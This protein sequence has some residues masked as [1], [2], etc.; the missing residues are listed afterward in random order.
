MNKLSSPLVKTYRTSDLLP[1][2]IWNIRLHQ[3]LPFFHEKTAKNG[4]F[5]VKN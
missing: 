3:N 5:S 1:H 4:R 2:T